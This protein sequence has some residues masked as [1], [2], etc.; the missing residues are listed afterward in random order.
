VRVSDVLV[1]LVDPAAAEEVARSYCELAHLAPK[2]AIFIDAN[3]I[4]PA[5]ARAIARRV[6]H[7][8]RSFVDGSINGL[9]KNLAT[10]GTLYLSGAGA[11]DVAAA[12][13]G[14]SRVRVLG[15]EPGRASAM[16][17]LLG[18]LSKGLCALFTELALLAER[19]GMLDAMLEAAGRTY[20]G[21]CAVAERMLP[22]YPQHAGRRATEMYEL[23]MMARSGVTTTPTVIEAVRRFH[24]DLARVFPPEAIDHADDAADADLK[25]LIRQLAERMESPVTAS[26]AAPVAV[27]V[28]TAVKEKTYG[29]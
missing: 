28:P 27:P 6:E 5:K 8:G 10:S 26:V 1:S 18:G 23:E 14:V 20:P 22:T 24:E 7:A 2:H 21:V 15:G 29:H 17:M 19:Q 16:K 12:F 9:A 4:G 11:D 13:D 3:S 25:S